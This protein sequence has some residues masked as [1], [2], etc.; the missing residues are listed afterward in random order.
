MYNTR[1]ERGAG[2][3][4]LS[5]G[6]VNAMRLRVM[7]AV[8]LF[9]GALFGQGGTGAISGSVTD[10]SGAVV[11][12]ATV[13]AI[14]ETTG[15]QRTT[16]VGSAGEY[17]IVGLQ[18]GSYTV[19]AERTGFKKFTLR[20]LVLQVDQN[21]RVDVRFEV[22][23]VTEIVEVVGQPALLQ[24]EQSSVG[25]V[26]DRQKI[27]EFPLNGRNFVQ[28]GLLLP[29]VNTG[30]DGSATGGGISVSG[31]RPEQNSFLLDGTTNSDQYQ[32]YL[33]IRPSVD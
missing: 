21:A 6:R 24:T 27:V 32:N 3:N 31:L 22:G 11:P 16:A 28:L 5:D 15:F 1:L 26:V 2:R 7:T 19:T 23:A 29:G 25:A 20:G 8:F 12:G 14:N 17:T 9:T 33:V 4:P 13:V 10:A 30:D 18:P